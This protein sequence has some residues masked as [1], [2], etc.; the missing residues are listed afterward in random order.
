MI[1]S[2][3]SLISGAPAGMTELVSPI[4]PFVLARRSS[5]R[6]NSGPVEAQMQTDKAWR[7]WGKKDP[8][9]GV[10]SDARYRRTS[11]ASNLEAFHNSGEAHWREIRA[12]LE[13]LYGITAKNV[14]VDFGCG[15]GRILGPMAHDYRRT[16]GIDISPDMLAEAARNC[17]GTELVT[18]DDT[19]SRLSGTVDLVHSVI[20]LQHIFP[21]RGLRLIDSLLRHLAPGGVAALHLTLKRPRK[22]SKRAI[23]FL[24]HHVPG[25]RILFNLLQGKDFLEPVMQMNQYDLSA[26][27]Q[28]F[29]ANDMT[30]IF[31]SPMDSGGTFSVMIFAQKAD[32]R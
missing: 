21:R 8:Y 9:Y 30:N 18:G 14:A 31:L 29:E 15:V 10:L 1:V 6:V 26:A 17:P 11:L 5:S 25:A 32:D 12:T 27:L 3:V 2:H 20:V 19:L 13:R 7:E 16:I 28:V 22:F 4:L 23:Y 24:K